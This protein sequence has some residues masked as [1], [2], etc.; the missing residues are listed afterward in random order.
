MAYFAGIVFLLYFL[1]FTARG[2]DRLANPVYS[3]FLRVYLKE[4]PS[5]K[6]RKVSFH[7][8]QVGSFKST[9]FTK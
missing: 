3:D 5:H 1:S 7:F 2:L 6:D 4:Y 9:Y 8:S